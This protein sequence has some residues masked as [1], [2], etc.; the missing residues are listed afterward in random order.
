MK[1]ISLIVVGLC[2]LALVFA[3]SALANKSL[4][5][6]ADVPL[7]TTLTYTVTEILANGDWTDNHPAGLIFGTLKFDSEFGIFTPIRYFA[8]D[9]GVAVGGVGKPNNIQFSYSEGNNPNVAAATGLGGLGKKGTITVTKA[10]LD[11]D[12][13]L[14]AGPKMLSQAATFGTLTKTQFIGGWPRIYVGINDGGNADLN[15]AGAEVF[16]AD[17]AAGTYNGILQITATIS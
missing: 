1:K 2:V 8:I 12:D 3:G 14:I 6:S 4:A 17:D 11:G 10:V 9:M 16:T 15:D 7:S 13:V 5:V